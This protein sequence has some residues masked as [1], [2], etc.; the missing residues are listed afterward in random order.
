MALE[1]LRIAAET[2]PMN[3]TATEPI[4]L[5]WTSPG[6]Q[7]GTSYA[8]AV[9]VNQRLARFEVADIETHL[10]PFLAAATAELAL[11]AGIAWRLSSDD[12]AVAL[13]RMI[14]KIAIKRPNVGGSHTTRLFEQLG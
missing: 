5:H 7:A 2:K 12:P 13:L 14:A 11:E 9:Q 6:H 4:D 1:P 3:P 8:T 10:L